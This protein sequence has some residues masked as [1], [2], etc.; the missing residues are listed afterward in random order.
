MDEFS[1]LNSSDKAIAIVGD[2]W[3]PQAAKQ[4]GDK[5]SKTFLR[6]IYRNSVMSAQLLEVSFLGVETVLRLESNT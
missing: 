2:R 4:E 6:S 1:T 3:W 5:I